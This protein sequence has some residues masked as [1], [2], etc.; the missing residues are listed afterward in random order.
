MRHMTTTPG[1]SESQ[2]D[3]V[4]RQIQEQLDRM[5]DS[6]RWYRQ[7][8]Y[9]YQA[10]IVTLAGLIT[11]VSGIRL[12]FFSKEWSERL[13]SILRDIALILGAG[14]SVMGVFV[15]VFSPRESW[16][17][18]AVTYVR[19]RALQVK[20]EFLERGSDFKDNQDEIVAQIFSEFQAILDDSNKMWLD[21]RKKTS[22][23]D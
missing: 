17:L 18:N 7:S 3:F 9:R 5:D 14:S 11:I 1:N 2:L 22:K 13:P 10:I 20:F 21:L 6:A 15:A 16:H 4:H 8:Y 23:S 19:M 12:D